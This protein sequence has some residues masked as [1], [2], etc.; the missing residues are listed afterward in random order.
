MELT[1]SVS[2]VCVSEPMKLCEFGDIA[3]LNPPTSNSTSLCPLQK[4]TK[5]KQLGARV[6]LGKSA[7]ATICF[8]PRCHLFPFL[9]QRGGMKKGEGYNQ[10]DVGHA[11]NEPDNGCAC[12]ITDGELTR[13]WH[14]SR[15]PAGGRTF[16]VPILSL[17]WARESNRGRRCQECDCGL[18]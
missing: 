6:C 10:E 1:N 13:R 14:Q 7:E 3:L 4:K 17:S 2:F 12:L 8:K 16:P 5:T 15:S 11:H 18:F 9:P